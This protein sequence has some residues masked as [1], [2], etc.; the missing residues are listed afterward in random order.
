MI[1]YESQD[2]WYSVVV[3]NT[4]IRRVVSG[5]QLTGIVFHYKEEKDIGSESFLLLEEVL[6]TRTGGEPVVV[7][8]KFT[9]RYQGL[10]LPD[11]LRG[12]DDP[13]VLYH[14]AIAGRASIKGEEGKFYAKLVDRGSTIWFA[15]R[16]KKN[17]ICDS[18]KEPSE[19][20]KS[21]RF[22]DSR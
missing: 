9:D 17:E 10:D 3:R 16:Q 21:V 4:E 14:L 18:C 22:S 7:S 19:I 15:R 6:L 1:E 2:F 5:S 11:A 20:V 8:V 12:K 13:A